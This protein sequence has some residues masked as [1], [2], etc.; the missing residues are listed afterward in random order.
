MKT[1]PVRL[2]HHKPSVHND[3]KTYTDNHHTGLYKFGLKI[4]FDEYLTD[5]V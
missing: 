4:K 1:F 2:D 3:L 5:F